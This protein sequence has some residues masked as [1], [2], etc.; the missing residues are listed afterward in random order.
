[1][2]T[3]Q[4]RAQVKRIMAARKKSA[5]GHAKPKTLSGPRPKK[6]RIRA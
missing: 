2:A 6:L 3:N 4:L 1:M 5:T